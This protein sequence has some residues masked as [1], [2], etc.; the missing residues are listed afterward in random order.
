VIQYKE[1]FMFLMRDRAE[2][3]SIGMI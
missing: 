2:G 1:L 3:H